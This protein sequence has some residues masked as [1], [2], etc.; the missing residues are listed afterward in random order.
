MRTGVLSVV[1]GEEIAQPETDGSANMEKVKGANTQRRS[2]SV[3][4]AVRL[5]E[6]LGPD[7]GS[8]NQVARR[9]IRFDLGRRGLRGAGIN[10]FAEHGKTYRVS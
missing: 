7:E 5:R 8:F 6:D 4:E 9:K 10:Q 3:A 1:E 2:V